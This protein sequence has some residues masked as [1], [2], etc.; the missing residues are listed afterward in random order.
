MRGLRDSFG[1]LLAIA[2]EPDD[3]D[4][5]RLRRRIGVVVGYVTIVA[6]LGAPFL[7]NWHPLAFLLAASLSAWSVVNLVV[8]ARTH[9]FERYVAALLTAGVV[10]TLV[11]GV[12][13]GGLSAG[14]GVI[15][16]FLTP[17]YAILALGPRKAIPWFAVF[18][19]AVLLTVLTDPIVRDAVQPPPYAVELVSFGQNIIL[20]LS[21]TFGLFYYTDVR[22]RAAEERSEELLTNAIPATIAARLKHGEARIAEAYPETTILFSD[23]AGF[24][25]WASA[26]PPDRVVELLDDLFS[27]FDVVA[28][29]CGMEKIKTIG[30]AYMAV[31]GAPDPEPR[32]AEVAITMARSMLAA[33][34]DWRA[35]HGIGLEIRIGMA[36]GPSVA[37]VIGQRRL[38]FDLW[39]D[40]V[41]TASRMESSG[42]PGRIQV[43]AG[44]WERLRDRHRFEPREVEVKG[45]GALRTYLLLTDSEAPDSTSGRT[46]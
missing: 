17:I 16:T 35:A 9:R 38:L 5:L 41:N 40:T 2:D 1:R 8:L 25:P 37:G 19:G 18:V 3:N 28:A 33:V 30:D 7:A 6:P 22:R 44:T 27:R 42:I 14:A 23:I 13:I 20:P 15:W 4:D 39:G 10:F 12:L 36:S 31:S 32:H 21:L 34:A 24:T 26:T 11:M 29:T 43:A 46:A 45:L